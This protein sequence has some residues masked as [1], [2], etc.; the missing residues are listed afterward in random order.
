MEQIPMRQD[1][2]LIFLR[3]RTEIHRWSI[4]HW[5]GVSMD[6]ASDVGR[7]VTRGYARESQSE[8]ILLGRRYD[9]WIPP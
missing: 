1:R 2:S 8:W 5:V 9:I 7:A 3:E 4:R 6:L